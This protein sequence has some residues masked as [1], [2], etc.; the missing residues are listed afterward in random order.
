MPQDFFQHSVCPIYTL[1]RESRRAGEKVG[2]WV[3]DNLGSRKFCGGDC[4]LDKYTENQWEL[5]ETLKRNK[6][7][8]APVSWMFLQK[9]LSSETADNVD[10]SKII[11]RLKS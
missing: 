5:G 2:S 7:S 6:S 10:I 11:G 9:M 8:L 1:E 3:W 4:V